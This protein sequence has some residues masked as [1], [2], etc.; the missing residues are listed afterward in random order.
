MAKS[1]SIEVQVD[2]SEV[3]FD[4]DRLEL[5]GQHFR[6][7]VDDAK[8]PGINILVSR[9]GKV[10]YREMYGHRDVERG[11]GVESDTIYRFYSMT[12]P[13]T[14]VA[15]M[16][17]YERGLFQLKDPISKWLPE[18]SNAR[19]FCGGDAQKPETRE[20]KREINVHDLLTHMSGLTYDFHMA[21]PVDE[22]YR[23]NGFNW[24]TPGDLEES[25]K[26]L[27]SLPLLFDP[28]TEWN[29]SYSTDVL[30][31]IIEVISGD[32]LDTYFQNNVFI[33]LGMSETRFQVLSEDVHRFASNYVP[34]PSNARLHL[35]DDAGKSRYLK[36]PRVLSGGGGLVS[37]MADYYRFIDALRRGGT[38]DG[39]RI[40]GRKTL[41]YMTSNHLPGGADLTEHGRALFSET[42]YDGVGFGLGFSVVVD[43]CK[44]NI[45][46]Q[47]GEYGWGGAA[48][49]AFWVDPVE[50][51]AVIFLTQL[52]P[53][54]TYPIRPELKALV[55]QALE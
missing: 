37:T 11:T 1:K 54:S 52:M 3:G 2:P 27:A 9:G 8:L 43:P 32:S 51:I 24:G 42:A 30:G 35:L 6:Q 16:Q 12:K 21:H 19:V 45:L 10:A 5:I 44:A 17:L 33:P 13:V 20:P 50:D 40:I 23:K 15:A 14:S 48:S 18:F 36:P 31:R 41:E 39:Q 47:K 25:C 4:A 34:N 22:I 7:Y 28:G 29:Y 55:Y 53:S 49:T 46:C 38:L 26:I